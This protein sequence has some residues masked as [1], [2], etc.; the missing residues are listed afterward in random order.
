MTAK[1]SESYNGMPCFTLTCSEEQAV[2]IR[3]IVCNQ[4]TDSEDYKLKTPCHPFLQCFELDKDNSY[5][6]VEFWGKSGY[7]DFIDHIN[8]NL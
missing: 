2:T 7:Q 3:G 8:K 4:Y 5:V 1:L 6:M